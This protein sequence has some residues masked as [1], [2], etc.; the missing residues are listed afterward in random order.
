MN[1]Q[2]KKFVYFGSVFD[3]EMFADDSVLKL[4]VG[5]IILWSELKK[6]ISLSTTPNIDTS[7]LATFYKVLAVQP[8]ES[9]PSFFGRLF[10][11]P[12]RLYVAICV[13][14][15]RDNI[16][17]VWIPEDVAKS[18]LIEFSRKAHTE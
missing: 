7:D 9:K 15:S 13:T 16:T 4:P 18:T 8:V 17:T 6:L 11:T 14:D 12:P 10:Q 2:Q 3:T 5:H 1:T